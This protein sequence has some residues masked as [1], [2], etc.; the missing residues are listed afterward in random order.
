MAV[1]AKSERTG[2][3]DRIAY[4][5]TDEYAI[6]RRDGTPLLYLEW[7]ENGRP[8]R[9]STR[10][11]DLEQAKQ[12]ARRLILEYAQVRDTPPADAGIAD[13]VERYYLRHGQHLASAETAKRASDVWAEFFGQ[14]TV[15]TLLPPRQRAFLKWM[16]VNKG[17]TE[18]YAR[19]VLGV[20]K[21]A[22][23][24]AWE[25]QE[26]TRVPFVRLPAIGAGYPHY[27]KREQLVRFLN[28]DMPD[29]VF[30]YCMIRL[31]T[32]CRGDATLDLQ[33]FQVDTHMGLINLNPAGRTQTKKFRPIVPLTDFLAAYLG[34]LPRAS[35]YVNWHGEQIESVRTTWR[36][37]RQSAGLPAWFVPKV[38]RHTVGTELRR[39]GVKGW[40]V[41]GQMGHKKGE[42]SP[43]TENY[44]KFDP[45]YLAGAK[46]ALDDWML[47]LSA[48][49]PRM[50]DASAMTVAVSAPAE[51][52]MPADASAM[53]LQTGPSDITSTETPDTPRFKVVGGTGFEPVTPTMSR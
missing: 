2:D 9:R 42:S 32:G 21:A 29:H 27:A 39:R 53:P 30:T 36:K 14:D 40:D 50:R 33:P 15:D 22:L 51:L 44:A 28:Q 19:R 48:E 37:L 23:N 5:I 6:V 12:A 31:N 26:I 35:H 18:S 24:L 7:R 16:I 49:V 1:D 13:V 52:P 38:I 11:A 8:V 34:K 20:G 45:E 3:T 41:S 43:T 4:R 25:D 46:R 17:W 47:E 10:C